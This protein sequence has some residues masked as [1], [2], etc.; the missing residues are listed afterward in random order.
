MISTQNYLLSTLYNFQNESTFDCFG[1]PF[2]SNQPR[3]MLFSIQQIFMPEHNEDDDN[4]E[5]NRNDSKLNKNQ[6][7]QLNDNNLETIELKGQNTSKPNEKENKFNNPG[8]AT[9]RATS[10]FLGNKTKRSD[11]TFQDIGNKKIMGR[12]LKNGIEIGE[13]NKFSEDNLMRKIKSHFLE[14]IHNLLNSNFKNKE[15]KFLRLFSTINENLKKDYNIELM[16][17]TIKELYE[18]SP[19]SSKYRR[20][21]IQN[22]DYNKKIIQQIY[23]ETNIDDIENDIISILNSTYIDS[24]K[25]FREKHFE[26]F[27][28]DIEKEE[29]FKGETKENINLYKEKIGKLFINYEKWFENKIGRKR[30][31]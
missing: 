27:L 21:R 8:N 12:K 16:K 17:K 15:R 11:L 4:N 20:Q 31:K 25:E 30:N 1:H 18:D 13:H 7:E 19:I 24:L 3:E 22:S 9:T 29:N 28:E 5:T 10:K 23:D 14:Y 2:D 6:D 26:E